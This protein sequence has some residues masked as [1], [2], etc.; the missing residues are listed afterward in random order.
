MG[1]EVMAEI[2][3]MGTG[4]GGAT[5]RSFWLQGVCQ[6][7][8][9]KAVLSLAGTVVLLSLVLTRIYGPWWQLLTVFGG[10]NLIQAGIT[11]VCPAAMV[12]KRLGMKPGVAFP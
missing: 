10:L 11:G 3:V 6:M 12:F 1:D 8:V 5:G 2:V 7:T 9:D 4:L